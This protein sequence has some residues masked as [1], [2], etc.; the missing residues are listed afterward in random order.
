MIQNLQKKYIDLK[1]DNNSR[2][3]MYIYAYK[4]DIITDGREGHNASAILNKT[5]IRRVYNDRSKSMSRMTQINHVLCVKRGMTSRFLRHY[6]N[7]IIY[8]FET[9]GVCAFTSQMYYNNVNEQL[10]TIY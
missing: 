7:I 4:M 2:G 3:A 6:N 9:A 10:Q 5:L 1:P 8:D